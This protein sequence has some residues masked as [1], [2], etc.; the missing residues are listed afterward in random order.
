MQLDLKDRYAEL[1]LAPI[2]I[3]LKQYV[4]LAYIFLINVL[5]PVEVGVVK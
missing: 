1:L 4:L 3:I 2:L 5:L